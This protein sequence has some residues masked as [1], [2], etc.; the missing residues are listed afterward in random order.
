MCFPAGSR[1]TCGFC[2]NGGFCANSW[3]EKTGM[4]KVT[5]ETVRS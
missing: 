1:S 4:V 5:Y 3:F 2:A